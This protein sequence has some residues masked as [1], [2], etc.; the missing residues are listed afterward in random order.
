MSSGFG[1]AMAATGGGFGGA[2]GACCAAS[3][4]TTPSFA[5]TPRCH[6]S[7]LRCNT[8]GWRSDSVSTRACAPLGAGGTRGVTYL[9]CAGFGTPAPFG[10]TSGGGF[11][12]G[13][14]PATLSSSGFGSTTSAPAFGATGTTTGFGASAAPAFGASAATGFGASAAPAFGAAPGAGFGA[15]STAAAGT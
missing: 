3:D 14:A 6:H 2:F 7:I 11:A 8:E 1:A 10:A 9:P 13:T 4:A 5:A 15:S 12:A